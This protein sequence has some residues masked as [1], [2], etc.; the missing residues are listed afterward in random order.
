MQKM[1]KKYDYGVASK[2]NLDLPGMGG[3]K[4]KKMSGDVIY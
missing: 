3:K 1:K 4:K 2:I